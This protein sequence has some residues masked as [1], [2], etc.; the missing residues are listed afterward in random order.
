VSRPDR[1]TLI[2]FIFFVILGGSN[3]VAVRISNFELPPFWGASMRF[4]AAAA[5]FWLIVLA[6]RMEVPRGRGLTGAGVYGLL[7]VGGAYGFLYW[8]LLEVPASVTMVVM[9]FGPLITFFLAILHRVEKFRWR[10]LVG[11]LVAL[12][13]IFI[14]VS[15]GAAADVPLVSLLAIVAGTACLAEGTVLFKFIPKGHPVMTNAIA[16]TTGAAMLVG[17]SLFAGE[18]WSL[19]VTT[20]TWLAYGYLVFFGSV[21]VFYLALFILSRWTASATSYA[22]LMFPI[23]TVIIAAWLLDEPIT[24]SFLFGAVL[25]ALGVWIGAISNP[26][27]AEV[28]QSLPSAEKAVS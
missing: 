11:A 16:L 12:V 10:G 19:P 2:A 18:T 27:G 15:G 8:G 9:A 24:I 5:V 25:V 1:T 3:A 22:F 17:I 20:D 14:G 28:E 21:G 23:S 13:G 6:L 26:K 7:T 4:A